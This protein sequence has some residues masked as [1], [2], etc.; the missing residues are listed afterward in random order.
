MT[1]I[2]SF[3]ISKLNGRESPVGYTLNRHVNVFFGPNGSG[4]TSI[5]R[6]IDSALENDHD[7]VSNVSFLKACVRVH[8]MAYKKSLDLLYQRPESDP[9][10]RVTLKAS[11]KTDDDL[12]LW[13]P[14]RALQHRR[15]VVGKHGQAFVLSGRLRTDDGGIYTFPQVDCI[16]K[17]EV[18]FLAAVTCTSTASW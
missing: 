13:P 4:K 16:W 5:L 11:P 17:V 3:E 18:S 15:M 10:V 2:I 8:S 14:P 1:D 12:L 7:L 6:I 9:V